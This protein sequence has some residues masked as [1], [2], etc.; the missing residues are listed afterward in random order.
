MSTRYVLEI[1]GQGRQ[2]FSC[3]VD[4][5]RVA[6]SLASGTAFTVR[7]QESNLVVLQNQAGQFID[8]TDYEVLLKAA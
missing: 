6:G 1:P 3:L 8:S 7:D 2:G 4:A 5:V